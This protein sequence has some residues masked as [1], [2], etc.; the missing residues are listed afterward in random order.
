MITLSGNAV[1]IP[2]WKGRNRFGQR[3]SSSN[4]SVAATGK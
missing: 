4:V 3:V 1:L 2:P